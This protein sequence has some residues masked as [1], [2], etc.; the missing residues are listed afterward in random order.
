MHTVSSTACIYSLMLLANSFIFT[1][2][3]CTQKVGVPNIKLL[4]KKW[5]IGYNMS[6]NICSETEIICTK[7]VDHLKNALFFVF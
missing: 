2:I 1:S 6:L 5:N 7:P 3:H 4:I